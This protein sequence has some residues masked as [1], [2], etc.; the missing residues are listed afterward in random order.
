VTSGYLKAIFLF[1]DEGTLTHPAANAETASPYLSDKRCWVTTQC[2]Q[3]Y[4]CT[5]STSFNSSYNSRSSQRTFFPELCVSA[6][7]GSNALD[8]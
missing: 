2:M 1:L 8:L 3:Q 5:A 7:C 4:I 6:R